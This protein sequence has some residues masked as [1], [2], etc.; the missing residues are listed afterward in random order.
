LPETLPDYLPKDPFSGQD[1]EYEITEKGFVLR[2]RAKDILAS[3]LV[4][5]P[6][7]PQDVVH[8]YEFEL[9]MQD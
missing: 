7:T 6:G 1:F 5:P 4:W 3:Q 9:Q 8:E 2:C